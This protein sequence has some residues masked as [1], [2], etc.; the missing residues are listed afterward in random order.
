LVH[1][2]DR[3]RTHDRRSPLVAVTDELKVTSRQ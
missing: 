3:V 2:C 1:N